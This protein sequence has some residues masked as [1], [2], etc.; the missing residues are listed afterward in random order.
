MVGFI[1]QEA[2][3]KAREVKVKVGNPTK[4][5]VYNKHILNRKKKY[6]G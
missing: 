1:K 4:K 2:L 3:E 5:Q 6:I